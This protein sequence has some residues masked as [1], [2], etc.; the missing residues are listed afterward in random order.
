MLIS[1]TYFKKIVYMKRYLFLAMGTLFYLKPLG[2]FLRLKMIR[3]NKLSRTDGQKKVT[4]NRICSSSCLKKS[5][6]PATFSVH[7]QNTFNV[8][9][10]MFIW[11]EMHIEEGG[12]VGVGAVGESIN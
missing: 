11:V 4:I 5:F 9:K 3:P 7:L 1:E 8:C 6:F 12:R 10:N 2:P